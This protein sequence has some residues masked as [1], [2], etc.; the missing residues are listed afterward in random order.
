MVSSLTRDTY[1]FLA[2][3]HFVVTSG[4]I[5]GLL[6]ALLLV[7]LV[8]KEV[9]RAVVRSLPP[10]TGRVFDIAAMPLLLAFAVVVIERFR[11][12]GF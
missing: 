11:A 8:E 7:L 9:T 4:R 2:S 12:L 10:K 3:H 6:L 1:S 5:G